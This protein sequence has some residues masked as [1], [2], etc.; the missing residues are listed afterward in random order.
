M[1]CK[2]CGKSIPDGTTFC[3]RCGKPQAAPVSRKQ[4]GRCGHR[5]APK[6]KHIL[7]FLL[8]PLGILMAGIIAAL[9][10]IFGNP[11]LQLARAVQASVQAYNDAITREAFPSLQ[12]GQDAGSASLTLELDALPG[13]VLALTS[14]WDPENRYWGI[15]AALSHDGDEAA[16]LYLDLEDADLT[17]Y[18]PDLFDN[19]ALDVNME[20]LGADL[21]RLFPGVFPPEFSLDLFSML[22]DGIPRTPLAKDAQINLLRA[23]TVTKS[24]RPQ[25]REIHGASLSCDHYQVTIPQEALPDDWGAD[26]LQ[27]LQVS[28]NI[29][30]EVWVHDGYIAALRW[31]PELWGQAWT[32]ELQLGGAGAYVDWGSLS[33]KTDNISLTVTSAGDHAASAGSFTDQTT[34]ILEIAG[35]E[36][37]SLQSD[38]TCAP[39]APGLEFHWGLQSGSVQVTAAGQMQCGGIQRLAV[40][41]LRIDL[42]DTH[43]TSHFT[44]ETAPFERRNPQPEQRYMLSDLSQEM[45][46]RWSTQ[47]AYRLI[48]NYVIYH[49]DSFD[50]LSMLY[51]W[52]Q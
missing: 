47:A 30:L 23:I 13:A 38:L 12:P 32:I 1:F 25:S 51:D 46:Q 17:C 15:S 22:P 36:V 35:Q 37:L 8:V 52:F 2:Y 10:F 49:L 50:T 18:A 3:M 41:Q 16:V 33:A 20:T 19:Q 43:L 9:L 4:S 6:K 7:P 42:G 26:F 40:D 44:W 5:Y 29:S 31:T 48:A 34:C 45:L 24:S 39:A 27:T 21:Q 28:G 14:D 11:K